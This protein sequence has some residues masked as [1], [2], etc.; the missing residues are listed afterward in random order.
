MVLG[1][2]AVIL[3]LIPMIGVVSFLLGLAAIGLGIYAVVKHKGKGQGIA[4]II[5]GAVGVMVALVVTLTT[6]AIVSLVEVDTHTNSEFLEN[7]RAATPD[8]HSELTVLGDE[9]ALPQGEEG[10]VSV[11]S[12]NHTD[13]TTMFPV[14]VHNTTDHAVTEINISGTAIDADGETLGSGTSLRLSPTVAPPGGYAYGYISID[15]SDL[16]LPSGAAMRDISVDYVEESNADKAVV[17]LD[18]ENVVELDDG[19]LSGD[20]TNQHDATVAV[21]IIDILC[22]RPDDRLSFDNT[23]VEAVSMVA[24]ESANW[25]LRPHRD[26]TDCKA[27]LVSATAPVQ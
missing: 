7:E 23:Y 25:T 20:V 10:E 17:N 24:G 3:A 15:S 18:I 6:G 9:D 13:Y 14:L 5:T 19:N 21:P 2:I 8:A 1:S 26:A 27:Q 4:G 22:V 11:V 16:H 12:I